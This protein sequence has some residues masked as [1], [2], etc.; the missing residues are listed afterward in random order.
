MDITAMRDDRATALD[1]PLGGVMSLGV[2]AAGGR[3]AGQQP[4]ALPQQR[5]ND[6][7]GNRPLGFVVQPAEVRRLARLLILLGA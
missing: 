1:S 5:K 4:A 7:G 2:H 6:S 3:A